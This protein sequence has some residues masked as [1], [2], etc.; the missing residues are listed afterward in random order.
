MTQVTT[1][2]GGALIAHKRRL[3]TPTTEE[4]FNGGRTSGASPSSMVS[5]TDAESFGPYQPTQTAANVSPRSGPGTYQTGVEPPSP[6]PPTRDMWSN[7]T[8][9]AEQKLPAR[10]TGGAS[11]SLQPYSTYTERT[12][13]EPEGQGVFSR[14]REGHISQ[15][16]R[17]ER[18]NGGPGGQQGGIEH[19][20]Q[21][22]DFDTNADFDHTRGHI[23][24]SATWRRIFPKIVSSS[25]PE[26]LNNYN[27]RFASAWLS[28]HD[29][30]LPYIAKYASKAKI[31]RASYGDIAKAMLVTITVGCRPVEARLQ[32]QAIAEEAIRFVQSMYGKYFAQR[33]SRI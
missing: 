29:N 20:V 8:G 28:N 5:A 23:V 9:T 10:S 15:P 30:L 18:Y 27:R 17:N 25:Q 7:L 32:T 2:N 4:P 33:L 12:Q 13:T 16:K 14:T 31:R 6:T 24:D 3:N 1:Y 11:E 19:L 26:R 22:M 21:L